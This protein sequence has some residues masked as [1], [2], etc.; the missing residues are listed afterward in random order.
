MGYAF[1]ISA[2]AACG[3]SFSYNPLRVPSVRIKGNRE[4]ICRPCVEGWSARKVAAGQPA[5]EIPADAYEPINEEL[6]L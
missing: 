4:P 1:V 6:L 3:N 5:L 2:C